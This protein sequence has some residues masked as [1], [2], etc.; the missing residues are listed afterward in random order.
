MIRRAVALLLVLIALPATAAEW[1]GQLP[2]AE[3][4]P[5]KPR[6]RRPTRIGTRVTRPD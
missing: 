6:R 2:E 4:T 1:I 5:S 3:C